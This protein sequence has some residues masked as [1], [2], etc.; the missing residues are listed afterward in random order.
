MRGPGRRNPVFWGELERRIHVEWLIVTLVL[1]SLTA[2]ISYFSSFLG[3]ARLDHT[4]YDRTLSSLGSKAPADDIIIIAIDDASIREMGYWPW[5]RSVH[6][7]LLSRLSQ[8]KAVGLDM[9]FSDPNPAYPDDDQALAQAIAAHGRVVLPVV[10]NDQIPEISPPLPVLAAAA[11]G[12]GSITAHA[13]E[14]GTIRSVVLQSALASGAKLDHFLLAMLEAGGDSALASRLKQQES[15]APRLIA[16]KGKPGSFTLYPYT[17]VLDGG[18]SPSAFSGKYVLV[19]SWASGLGD[20]FSTPRSINGEPMAGVEVLAN[21]LQN[22]L[23][24]TWIG[25]FARWQNALF[26]VLPVLLA[27]M[28]LPRFSPRK[29]FLASGSML[30]LIFAA[31]WC[32]MY[33]ANFWIPPAASAIGVALTYPVWS[34]RSQE[35]ALQYFD[36]E[37]QKLREEGLPYSKDMAAGG[38]P[39]PDGSLSS[40]VIKLHQAISLLR[41]AARQR[42]ETL[43][44]ISHDMRSPQNSIL[45]LTEL[46]ARSQTPLPPK[47][48]LEQIERYANKTLALVDGFIHLARAESMEMTYRDTNLADL[49]AMVCDERWPLSQQRNNTITYTSTV[50]DARVKADDGMLARAFGNL[51]DNAIIYSP[52]GAPIQCDLTREGD[53]WLV[54][55]R[56][57]G[58]GISPDQQASL[59]TPFKRFDETTPGNP[60]GSGLGLAFVQ[61][62]VARHAGSITVSSIVGSGSTFSVTLP[63]DQA[64]EPN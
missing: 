48:L 5:R 34:W 39:R 38:A 43:R 44:F 22:A 33:Y 56:D 60:T 31:D 10:Y 8:A 40:R 1:L 13:D 24:D 63:A 7:Q 49:L 15:D 16:Y 61:T 36:H 55:V 30:L 12:M 20:Y 62:V 27:C 28:L 3:L 46:Q 2:L 54:T 9:V 64:G 23:D 21:G 52:D 58:R 11:K 4:F 26:A 18:I 59:F 29:S 51:L 47:N 41:Q 32:F 19:G 25:S 45:A 17:R 42:E 35:A 37:L 50:D 6:A 57:Q 14:D 53:H